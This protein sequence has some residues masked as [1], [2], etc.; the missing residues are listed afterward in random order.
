MFGD[1]L[2]MGDAAMPQRIN[3]IRPEKRFQG[4]QVLIGHK[5]HGNA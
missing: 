5:G 4:P 3:P 1:G 2:K